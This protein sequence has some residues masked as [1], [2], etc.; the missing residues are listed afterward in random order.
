MSSL[1]SPSSSSLGPSIPSSTARSN[2]VDR[3]WLSVAS[4]ALRTLPAVSSDETCSP[5]PSLAPPAPADGLSAVRPPAPSS[6]QTVTTSPSTSPSISIDAEP[7]RAATVWSSL[8]ASVLSSLTVRVFRWASWPPPTAAY[9]PEAFAEVLVEATEVVEEPSII[10][11][12]PAA[13]PPAVDASLPT[14]PPANPPPPPPPPPPSP[15]RPRVSAH[16]H[17]CITNTRLICR[18][19]S[20]NTA[21]PRRR[22]WIESSAVAKRAWEASGRFAARRNGRRTSC[23]RKWEVV[24]W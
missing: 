15:W 8:A 14:N 9:P 6:K 5:P 23:E 7:T 19:S 20:G 12:T 21:S 17:A 4:A 13:M 10:W 3:T 18:P 16:P 22:C 11:K 24:G 2:S 1:T